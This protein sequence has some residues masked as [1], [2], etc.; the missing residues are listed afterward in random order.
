MTTTEIRIDKVTFE[1]GES[2]M[3]NGYPGTIIRQYSENM[4]EVRL[5][6]GDL[7]VDA[8]DIDKV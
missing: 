6:S 7:C 1:A 4:Y 2:V 5:N 8:C 3:C